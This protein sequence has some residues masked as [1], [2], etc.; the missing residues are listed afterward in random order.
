MKKINPIKPFSKIKQIFRP[1][2]SNA[3]TK[4]RPLDESQKLTS[5][6][7]A[8]SSANRV[9]LFSFRKQNEL[10]LKKF[11][12]TVS[13]N[14]GLAIINGAPYNG[15]V[16]GLIKDGK[17]AITYKDGKVMQSIGYKK[18]ATDA[19]PA[20][21]KKTFEYNK[22]ST[23][24]KRY[25]FDIFGEKLSSKTVLEPNKVSIEYTGRNR[26]KLSKHTIIKPNGEILSFE[27]VVM[28]N[29]DYTGLEVHTRNSLTG[30]F[31]KEDETRSILEEN[32]IRDFD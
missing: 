22:N 17:I 5:E 24:I 4:L 2:K 27:K 21:F 3:E 14:K 12:K 31:I 11:Q 16:S 18:T 28:P 25:E 10:P 29:E 23:T 26:D 1:K 8:L 7:E 32:N 9:H 13:F 30:E 15:V 19:L 6:M 20:Y